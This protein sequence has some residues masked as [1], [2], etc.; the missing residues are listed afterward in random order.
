MS[1]QEQFEHFLSEQKKFFQVQK[2]RFEGTFQVMQVKCGEL[3]VFFIRFPGKLR[4]YIIQ[5]SVSI[6]EKWIY[7][8]EVRKYIEKKVQKRVYKLIPYLL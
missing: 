4:V 2:S 7:W 8:S 1:L 6:L 3:R 5:L